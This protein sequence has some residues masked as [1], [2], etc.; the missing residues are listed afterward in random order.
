MKKF[1]I[2]RFNADNN[3]TNKFLIF[4]KEEHN[5]RYELAKKIT[6]KNLKKSKKIL[7]CACGYGLG[8]K[9]LGKI[10]NY[11]G[12]D[13]SQRAIDYCKNR[14]PK[15]RFIIGDLMDKNLL[16]NL[17][18]V[19]LITCF[20]TI[21]H[22]PKPEIFLS[23]AYNS[24]KRGGFFIM[25]APIVLTKDWD[26]YH[27]HDKSALEWRNELKKA[28]FMIMKELTQGFELPIKEVAISPSSKGFDHKVRMITFII[29]HPRYL[30]DR[31][32]NWGMKRKFV[33]KTQIFICTKLN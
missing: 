32:I 33:W 18:P 15:G 3:Y 25:S 10:S 11:I 16:T 4:F 7:D 27:L 6:L 20:E 2:E 12:I 30:Y 8:Y 24:L 14:Y 31:L 26:K 29:T 1:D 19:D 9:Y 21:E 22:L 23:S 13:I 5:K 17:S 28:G